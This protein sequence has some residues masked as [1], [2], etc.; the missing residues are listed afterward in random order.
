MRYA[1]FSDLHDNHG[2]LRQVLQDAERHNADELLCLGD[3]GHDPAIFQ[4]LRQRRIACTFG[5]WEVSGWQR[6]EAKLA[7]WVGSWPAMICRNSVIFCHAT[8]DMPAAAGNTAA[9]AVYQRGGVGWLQLFPRLHLNT[10]ARWQALAGLETRDVRAAFH[11]HTHIQMVWAWERASDKI[12]GHS[13]SRGDSGTR[14]LHS[15]AGPA[16]FVLAAGAAEAPNR[17][18]I[19]VGS[20]GQPLDGPKCATLCMMI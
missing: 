5:N 18:L 9:A 8:P 12:I 3:A 11:G 13:A 17:Y 15:F 2:A 4:T 6:L 10:E 16:E 20:A 14:R 7:A 19:G 1:I